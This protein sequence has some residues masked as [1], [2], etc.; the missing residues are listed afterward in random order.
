MLLLELS[1][2]LFLSCCDPYSVTPGVVVSA[3]SVSSVSYS[4]RTA[5]RLAEFDTVR[6]SRYTHGRRSSIVSLGSGV[7]DHNGRDEQPPQQNQLPK[8]E[9][10]RITNENNKDDGYDGLGEYD[11][12]EDIKPER[13]V[14]VGDP[15]LKVK[16]KGRSVTSILK[17]L[18][19]IQQQGPQKYCILGT[20]HCSYL[21][22]QI[23]ELL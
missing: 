21:H 8:Q 20:R 3:F 12:S 6:Q 17:E 15:Q 11:P 14:V 10:S 2:L 7:N 4:S 13:E 23:I 16:D 19:A 18:A 22:Q 5:K 9:E 1:F